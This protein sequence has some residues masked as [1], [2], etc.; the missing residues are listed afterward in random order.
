MNSKALSSIGLII[1]MLG[2]ILIFIWGPP[3]PS[4]QPSFGISL[5]SGTKIGDYG[6]TVAD[7]GQKVIRRKQVYK[8]MSKIGLVFVFVGFGCQ[9]WAVW[10]PEKNTLMRS[11]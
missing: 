7:L 9:L 6:E 2:V 1:G 4:H 10:I 11:D 5:E 8:V 3:Q